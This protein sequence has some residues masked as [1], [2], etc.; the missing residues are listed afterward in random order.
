MAYRKH[1][2]WSAVVLMFIAV[3]VTIAVFVKSPITSADSTTK[4]PASL[5]AEQQQTTTLGSDNKKVE[6]PKE[7]SIRMQEEERLRKQDK[8]Y[9]QQMKALAGQYKKR[10]ELVASAGGDPKP[11]LEAAA[12]F[13]A[14]AQE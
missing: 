11:L 1:F 12:K 3:V 10:A 9:P 2:V 6:V 13:E 4:T 8:S 7:I 14:R 5:V